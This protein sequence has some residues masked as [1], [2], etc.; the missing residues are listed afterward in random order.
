MTSTTEPRDLVDILSR[1]EFWR[2]EE[3][4]KS[5]RTFKRF[6]VRGD[7]R[8]E[9][10]EDNETDLSTATV[11]LRDVSRA[12]VGFL[13]DKHLDAG[14]F[15]RIHF[16]SLG[17]WHPMRVAST[18]VCVRFCR[19]VQE[20]LYLVGGQFVVEPLTLVAI[21]VSEQDLSSDYLG[22]TDANNGT[23]FVAPENIDET[24]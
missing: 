15:W 5:Q 16:Q 19:L 2:Q 24:P 23:E 4:E 9:P 22:V 18:C 10:L 21:G 13:I 20:G 7:A 1:M 17:T 8:L 14:S 6:S 12:G 11:S 3:P